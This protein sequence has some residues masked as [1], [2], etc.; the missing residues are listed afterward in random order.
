MTELLCPL[1]VAMAM[2]CLIDM[3]DRFINWLTNVHKCLFLPYLQS[4]IRALITQ[5]QSNTPFP[6][7]QTMDLPGFKLKVKTMGGQSTSDSLVEAA[8]SIFG[9]FL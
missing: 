3:W 1:F 8:G 7:K 2:L 6:W 9:L 4:T 5:C